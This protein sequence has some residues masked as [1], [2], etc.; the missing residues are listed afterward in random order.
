MFNATPSEQDLHDT[1][2]P[3]FEASVREGHVGIVMGAYNDLYNEP[4]CSNHWLLTD[5][6]RGKWGF[7]GHV[8]SDCGAVT[9]IYKNHKEVATPEEA[10]AVAIKAGCDLE[11][12]TTFK[13]L[14]NAVGIGL[15]TEAELNQALH[16]VL[17]TRFRLGMFDPPERVPFSKIGLD[18]NDSPEHAALALRTAHESLV[19]LKNDRGALPLDLAKLKHIA[20]L[21]ENADSVPMLLGNYNGT[22]S[23]P[24]TILA[25]IRAAAQAAGVEV[26]AA[27]GCP[28]AIPGPGG[29]DEAAPAVQDALR[30]ARDA[31]TIIYVGGI[32]PRLE[33]E[34][35]R[36][37]MEGFRGGDRTQIELPKG[38]TRFL[39][40]LQETGK[41]VV[42]VNCS[43][44]AVAF[45]W[46]AEHLPAILQAWYPGQ[47]GGTAVADVLFGKANPSGRLPVT[48]YRA[49]TDL[50]GFE[51]YSMANRTYRYFGGQALYPF[52]HGLSYTTFKYDAPHAEQAGGEVKVQVKV[53]NSG[54]CS[55]DEVV[56]VY[57][58]GPRAAEGP[59]RWLVATQ[60]VS[61][62]AGAAA[63]VDL[64]V[65]ARAL[66]LWDTTAKDYKVAPGE[67]QFEVGASSGDI[68]GTASVEVKL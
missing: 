56:Q 60:R 19:L 29:L 31:D 35:M 51:D 5:L 11:C 8:V 23:H 39:Q 17:S 27:P 53:T 49:T 44:S 24:V 63:E 45:P 67:Y 50:P 28:L 14:S 6:L 1:Y 42:F 48:F 68:R 4:C 34:E 52:G 61:L 32:S 18:Q 57:A 10:A 16:H 58:R 26:Q 25:G 30:I 36:V 46:E 13:A 59:K 21:G 62:K 54:S 65:T 43:G 3:Q 9:D 41:P 22:P 12:G 7:Q 33:G 66:R 20:V 2:L 55:G 38:Q 15:I 37:N 47:A 64:Q 40:M